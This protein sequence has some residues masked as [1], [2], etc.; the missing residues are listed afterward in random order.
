MFDQATRSLYPPSFPTQ[1]S[2]LPSA[3]V[4]KKQ[5]LRF[6]PSVVQCELSFTAETNGPIQ[7][8]N[9]NNAHTPHKNDDPSLQFDDVFISS[10]ND[11]VSFSDDNSISS[12]EAPNGNED[13][14]LN[15]DAIISSIALN[16]GPSDYASFTPSQKAVTSLM[17]LLDSMQCPDYAF[18]KIMEWART[19]FQAG[20]D[21]NPQC[22]TRLGN[23]K[24]MYGSLHNSSK[25]LPHLET[26]V[27][28]DPLPYASKLDV[29]CYDFVPQ[30]LSILQDKE[31]MTSDNLVLDPINPLAMYKP[32]NGRL[33]DALSGSVYQQMYAQLVTDPSRQLLC[34]LIAYTDATSVDS[35]SRFVVEPFF[36]V[37]AILK[38]ATRSTADAWR[39]FGY[40]QQLKSNLKSDKRN[41]SSAAKARNYHAQISTMLKSLQQV[42]SG[43]D[44]RLQNVAI[45]LF[46]KLVQVEVLCPILFIASD[47]PAADKLCGHFSN[48]N[49]YVQRVTC[50]CDCPYSQLDNPKY[51]CA[52]VTWEA[53]NDII[54]DGTD[55]DRTSISQHKCVNAFTNILIG[56]PNYKI[57][58]SVPTDP[59][60][61]VDNSVMEKVLQLIFECMTDGQKNRLDELAQHF[62]RTHRQSTR[63][64]F[65]QT[66]FS[67]GVTTISLKTAME[68]TG[69]VFLLICLAQFD[70]GWTLLDDALRRKGHNT[71]LI[72][73]LD[74]LES[75]SCF[76]AWTRMDEFWKI[77][78]Q[79]RFA[80]EAK[81]DLAE[82]LTKLRR[83]LPRNEGNG[84]KLPTFHNIM[85]MV[86]DMCKYGKPKEANTEVGEKNHKVFAK[87]IGRRCRKQHKTFAKQVAIRL[88]D[89]FIINK[90]A[91][92]ME[93]NN[94]NCNV[95][96]QELLEDVDGNAGILETTNKATHFM[97]SMIDNTP[98]V[99]WTS[100]TEK[101][102]L[103]FNMSL[104]EFIL[105]HFTSFTGA[106]NVHSGTEYVYKTILIRCHPCYK[107]EGPWF[108]WVSIHFEE[109]T[110]KG[111]TYPDDNYPCKV[112]A[113]I[114]KQ[115]NTFLDETLLVVQSAQSR[116]FRDSKLFT[117]WSLMDGYH[118]VSVGSVKESLFVLELG[119]GKIAV[120]LP[121]SEWPSRFTK[122]NLY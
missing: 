33:G 63:K 87:R 9:T 77:S 80:N 36:F 83:R 22:T 102:L 46:G 109:C 52:P 101:H 27:L 97:L 59:M 32:N 110:S 7:I 94:D 62:H 71:N 12:L 78:Q 41:L 108:D 60:H 57:F 13:I 89:T 26:I 38:H 66:D 19:S 37:P 2:K 100:A 29:I 86:S 56:D 85:H 3:H 45:Y 95:E 51:E 16:D 68:E 105:S 111:K 82:M 18:E 48:Y 122:T 67:N 76:H 81:K 15:H 42:Q 121:Y 96:S 112:L 75:L 1:R 8:E 39:P 44:I 54:M 74:T 93:I 55:D 30:L 4:F 88:S 61:A 103:S 79:D 25:M 17:L 104:A 49:K 118:I 20:F 92:V 6:N 64:D 119:I 35:N 115:H 11:D 72:Q 43:E 120:A 107:G 58:G 84:W 90:L 5:R 47:T 40:V 116:T 99:K 24:W 91:T 14:I 114:P 69:L 65:P 70:E 106:L 117:E 50:S 10:N 31:M 113:I 53:M 23:L 34:P 73:V 28:P 98:C 21:F